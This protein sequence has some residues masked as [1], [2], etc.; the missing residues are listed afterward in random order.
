[1]TAISKPISLST[2]APQSGRAVT[3]MAS[4]IPC[5]PDFPMGQIDVSWLVDLVATQVGSARSMSSVQ[6]C[7]KQR[8]LNYYFE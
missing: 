3:L 2:D 4:A 6:C 1:M 5:A 7:C 8:S